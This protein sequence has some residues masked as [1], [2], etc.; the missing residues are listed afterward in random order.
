MTVH[1]MSFQDRTIHLIDT[2]G[3]DDSGRTDGETL[4][5]LSYWLAAA[6]EREIQLSGIIYLHRITDTRLQ[7]SASRGLI[8]FKKMCG[9]ESYCGIVIAT[10]RWDELAPEQIAAASK[11]QQELRERAWGDIVE[12]GGRVVALSAARIDAM[13]IIK[14]IVN[15]DRRLTLDFQKQ[16]VDEGRPIHK[17]D[18]GKV[19]FDAMDNYQQQFQYTL[20]NSENAMNDAITTRHRLGAFQ[21]SDAVVDITKDM[22]PLR[23]DLARMQQRVD[24]VRKEWERKLQRD[25]EVLQEASRLNKE[26]LRRKEE[27]LEQLRNIRSVPTVSESYLVEEVQSLEKEK[28]GIVIRKRQRLEERYVG[29]HTRRTTVL[30]TVGTALAVGQLVAAMACT[31]M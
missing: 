31:V 15:R 1:T 13:N 2:P 19:L 21:V 6:Y 11:R 28:E 23:D 10:T 7:G 16:I 30:S 29:G 3:F 9:E 20:Q 17:T 8:A 12:K 26:R 24:D 4:Q 27:Q 18:A 25:A 5:E 14:H 22:R